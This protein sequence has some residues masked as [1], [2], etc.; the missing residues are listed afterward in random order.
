M[1][2]HLPKLVV[3]LFLSSMTA[4]TAAADATSMIRSLMMPHMTSHATMRATPPSIMPRLSPEASDTRA[5]LRMM[6]DGADRRVTPRAHYPA[7]PR[8]ILG[9]TCVLSSPHR[10]FAGVL[11]RPCFDVQGVAEFRLGSS[12]RPFQ[13]HTMRH[14]G[15]ATM[16]YFGPLRMSAPFYFR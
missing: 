11:S 7:R 13:R 3:A 9:Y 6:L 1:S 12:F 14:S 4:Q 10:A 8:P 5:M 2:R 15:L 16:D